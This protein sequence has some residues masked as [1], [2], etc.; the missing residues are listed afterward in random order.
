MVLRCLIK[1]KIVYIYEATVQ[2]KGI[3]YTRGKSSR[4]N[5]GTSLKAIK[6][7]GICALLNTLQRRITVDAFWSALDTFKQKYDPLPSLSRLSAVFSDTFGLS[8]IG[9]LLG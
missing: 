8:K 3:D 5:V 1:Y 6:N 9:A 7:Q 2:C 4:M